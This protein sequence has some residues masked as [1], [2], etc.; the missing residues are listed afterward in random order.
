M[1]NVQNF[2]NRYISW[3]ASAEPGKPFA[4]N[5]EI[6]AKMASSSTGLAKLFAG[7]HEILVKRAPLSATGALAEGAVSQKSRRK[8]QVFREQTRRNPQCSVV[9]FRDEELASLERP[10]IPRDK[11]RYF[12]EQ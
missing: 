5:H 3:Q 11:P 2:V 6:L 10:R 4:K 1:K 9:N 8:L 7:N 12:L